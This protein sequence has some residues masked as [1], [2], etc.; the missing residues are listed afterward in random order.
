MLIVLGMTEVPDYPL[1]IYNS[2]TTLTGTFL[3]GPND[4]QLFFTNGGSLI[5][6]SPCGLLVKVLGVHLKQLRPT[7]VP[8]D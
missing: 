6:E 5:E 8:K 1:R 2:Y 7:S 3:K 4:S